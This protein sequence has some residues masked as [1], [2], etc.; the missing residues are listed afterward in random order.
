MK[1]PQGSPLVNVRWKTQSP[2]PTA[3]K[4][5]GSGLSFYTL[6]RKKTRV[7]HQHFAGPERK[8][9][10]RGDA[11]DE[12]PVVPELIHQGEP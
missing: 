6:D 11:V 1:G 7:S 2:N 8:I 4:Q 5:E 12:V 9:I 3:A 10:P